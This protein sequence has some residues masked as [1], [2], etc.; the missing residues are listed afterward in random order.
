MSNSLH[1]IDTDRRLYCLSH[2]TGY[3]CLGFDVAYQQACAVSDWLGKQGQSA[4]HVDWFNVG[5][6]A[7]Y[8]EHCHVMQCAAEF[9]QRTGK[10]C[11]VQLVPELTGLEGQRVEVTD[12][13]GETRRFKVGKSTGWMPCHLELANRRS[14]GGP[15]VMGLP[16][17][18]VRVVR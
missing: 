15:S 12:C 6:E 7:G 9:C 2:G 13:D 18:S 4:S 8:A 1:K 11:D 17:K 14:H 16:F 3:T 5:T 10:R